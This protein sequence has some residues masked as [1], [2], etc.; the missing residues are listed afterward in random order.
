L[1][2]WPHLSGDDRITARI[3]KRPNQQDYHGQEILQA[4]QEAQRQAQGQG[5]TD[6]EQSAH[7]QAAG[8]PIDQAGAD[9]AQEAVASPA[10]R[11][12]THVA[13]LAPRQETAC[14][15]RRPAGAKGQD[16]D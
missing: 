8:A 11:R 4:R 2:K 9:H 13:D 1:P 16:L 14:A 6:G 15:A 3:H 5:A 12:K 10:Q 7:G